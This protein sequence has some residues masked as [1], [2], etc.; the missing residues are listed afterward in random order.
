M[1]AS[2]RKCPLRENSA[3]APNHSASVKKAVCSRRVAL[4]HKPNFNP[5][6][7]GECGGAAIEVLSAGIVPTE[8]PLCKSPR[9]DKTAIPIK[10]DYD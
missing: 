2:D 10:K 7:L 8:V 5:V 6:L 3:L 9:T 1:A 4:R